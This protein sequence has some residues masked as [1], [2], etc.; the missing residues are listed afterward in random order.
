[1][2]LEEGAHVLMGEWIVLLT[3]P[4]KEKFTLLRVDPGFGH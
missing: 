2:D 3:R 4:I 1:V